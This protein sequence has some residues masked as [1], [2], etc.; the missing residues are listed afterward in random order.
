MNIKCF[1]GII[2][3]LVTGYNSTAGQVFNPY[4]LIEGVQKRFERIKDYQV[5]ISITVDINFLKMPESHA[6]ITFKQPDKIKLES[7]GFAL[8]PKQGLNFLPTQ[9]LNSNFTAI[10]AGI[11]SVENY[12][13]HMVKVVPQADS[14]DI[15]LSTLW[16]DPADNIIRKIETT[17]K[18]T[19]TVYIS[20]FYEDAQAQPLPD[21]VL[22]SF[23]VSGFKMPMSMSADFEN[24]EEM[25]GN[26]NKS[27]SGT[28]TIKYGEYKINS[29]IEDSYFNK[30]DKN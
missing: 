12:F 8:L 6:K 30:E 25:T 1:V 15:I 7:D 29:G 16:I 3:L 17:T 24:L 28:V 20:L 19:G 18:N 21:T 4:E 10:Y 13:T 5:D 14:I 9:L 27:M 2:L 26:K 23:N 22:F 11:D